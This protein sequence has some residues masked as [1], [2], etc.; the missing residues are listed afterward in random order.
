M[1]V[2]KRDGQTEEFSRNKIYRSVAA[3]GLSPNDAN[4][5]TNQVQAWAES[6]EQETVATQE[7]R[8]KVIQLL[9]ERDPTVAE[10][11]RNYKKAS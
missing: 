8:N 10:S 6:S 1:Q 4:M 3:A 2:K 11:Y 5:V 7:I 9:E